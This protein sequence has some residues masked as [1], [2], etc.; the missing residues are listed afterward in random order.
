MEKMLGKIRHEDS[1]KKSDTDEY[2]RRMLYLMIN[3]AARCLEER[4]VE[5]PETVDMAMIL[6]TGF[7]A[8]R[9][10]LINYAR[11]IGIDKIVNDLIQ[12]QEKFHSDRFKPNIY[13]WYLK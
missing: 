4:V 7:P 8:F 13:L 2:L 9:G 10:G 1:D 12:F 6:G 11:A 3:E 5:T